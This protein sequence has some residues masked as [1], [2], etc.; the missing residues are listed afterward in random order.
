MTTDPG[1]ACMTISQP[2]RQTRAW[3]DE[4]AAAGGPSLCTLPPPMAREAFVYLQAQVQVELEPAEVSE[5]N[6]PWQGGSLRLTVVRPAQVQGLTPAFIFAHGGGWIIGDYPTHERLV[7]KLVADS[8]TTAVFVHY[9]LSPEAPFPVAI[10]E[11]YAVTCW[12]AEHGVQIGVDGFR[13]AVAGNSVGGNLS[14]VLCLMAKARGGPALRFQLLMCPVTAADFTT[15]SYQTFAE[16]YALTRVMMLWFWDAYI[17]DIDERA[18][19]WAAPLLASRDELSGLPPALIQTAECDVLRDEGEAYG[20]ALDAAGVDV[21]V[22]RYA[23]MI[24][25]FSL[26]NRL[27]G[28]PASRTAVCQAAAELRRHL[29]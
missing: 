16:G 29:T 20:R 12:V 5:H 10:E 6:L 7:R 14:A 27:A 22:V 24:H 8:G 26:L 1:S 9:S 2:E 25:D 17:G 19:S 4:M 28:L 3:L 15:P 18:Q 13:L 21:S 23:G 11:L